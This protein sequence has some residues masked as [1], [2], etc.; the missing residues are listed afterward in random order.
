[1]QRIT[2]LAIRY[3]IGNGHNKFRIVIGVI[4]ILVF[5]SGTSDQES[6]ELYIEKLQSL[7]LHKIKTEQ[8][9]LVSKFYL[10]NDNRHPEK[11]IRHKIRKVFNQ[12][13]QELKQHWELEYLINWPRVISSKNIVFEAHHIVPIAAGGINEWWNISPLPSKNHK[14]IHDSLEEQACFS[15]NF[16][17]QRIVR[18][19][20]RL[21]SL[22]FPIFKRYLYQNKTYYKIY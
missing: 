22:V 15:H 12:K 7:S 20:L 14:L 19:I 17:K 6:F 13:R 3:L 21:R 1:M 5:V 16:I 10:T 18:F 4:L 8:K 2:K 11:E 9:S